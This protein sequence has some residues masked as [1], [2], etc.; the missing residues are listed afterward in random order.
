MK[1]FKIGGI[2]PTSHKLSANAPIENVPLPKKAIVPLSQHI[3]APA[4]PI[5]EKGDQVK[6][7]QVI[8]E[9]NGFVSVNVHA[10]ISGV[11]TKI[12]TAVDGWGLP[13]PSIFIDA[14]GDGDEWLE[15][16]D[17]TPDINRICKLNGKEII[18][19]IQDAGIVGL[20]GACFPTH[21]KL[22]PPADCKIEVL[23]I[24]AVECEP[25]LTCDHQ[26]MLEHAE[27]IFIGI[28]LVMRALNIERAI[29]GI[30]NNKKD[31][32]E[33]FQKI[34]NRHFGI[35]VCPLKLRYP[36]GGEKQLIDA[37]INRQVA[38]GALPLSVGAVVQ[39]V[40]TVFAI[41]E[42][43]QK[44]KPLID[45]VMTV[46]GESV[47]RRGNYLVRFGTPLADVIEQA[48]GI[49]EDTGKI[50][51]GGPM[52]GKAMTSINM[53][54]HKRT[55]GILIMTEAE[56]IRRE[57]ENCMRCGKCV[58]AC[59]MGLEPFLLVRQAEMRLWEDMEKNAIMD[60]IE[61]GCCLYSCPSNRPLL[62]YVRMGKAKV[63]GILRERATKK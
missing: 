30:E 44:N 35:E 5:V 25:Y 45:R 15:T 23:I 48:G 59:P 29:V 63:G 8:A 57:P 33:L 14:E 40:A 50:I 39:N 16:I 10:P 52:M 1:T 6:V 27:E 51:A 11:V 54:A 4:K 58:E 28:S 22:M 26:L 49:P 13:M 21:V 46:T 18:K 56:S 17:R 36:Q 32:I 42:A 43:V 31:A 55:S 61:C 20:G 38:S 60:C 34:A 19:K 62:D 7:G 41:Y 12:D 47:T 3:G 9:A 53:P 37:T 24:N 2:H